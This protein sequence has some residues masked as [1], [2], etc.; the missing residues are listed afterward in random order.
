VETP[1]GKWAQDENFPVGSRLIAPAH[2]AHVM[3]YYA[4]ARAIDDIA[5]SPDL[6]PDTKVA[7]LDAFDR[8]L[9]DPA[10]D[11]P[12]VAKATDLRESLAETGVPA[13]HGRDLIVA[14]KQDATKT[15]YDDW[16]ELLGYCRY[17]AEPV[18]RYLLDLHGEDRALWPFSDALC[19][20]LQILNHLQD[21]AED[22]RNL[23][24]VYI[25]QSWLAAEGEGV[26]SL[27]RDH[28]SPGLRRV[29]NRCLAGVE[30]LLPVAAELPPRLRSPRLA[31]ES[32]AIVNLG[33]VITAEL[34]RR[35]P[36]A[37]RVELSK[38]RKAAVAVSGAIG[39]V[40][41]RGRGRGAARKPSQGTAERPS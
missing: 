27:S 39:I 24:R 14:F 23:D 35:D 26:S 25:P 31:M 5:D 3:R 10:A 12:E 32:A 20:L 36:L 41:P 40:L 8:A 19:T 21:C 15:R 33:R 11:G 1:S 16:G 22:Y 2:R 37:E 9:L 34:Y 38:G 7:R 18:G 4:F 13:A 17:S 28:A 29:L 6:D 30:E